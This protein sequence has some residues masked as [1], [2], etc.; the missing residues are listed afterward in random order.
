M[1]ASNHL[2]PRIICQERDTAVKLA[3]GL[4]G[5]PCPLSENL[6]DGAKDVR[7]LRVQRDEFPNSEAGVSHNAPIVQDSLR[8]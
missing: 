8:K 7:L 1:E 4:L 3:L 5:R 2:A 6:V